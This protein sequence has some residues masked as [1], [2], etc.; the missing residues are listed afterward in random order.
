MK[1]IIQFLL[2]LTALALLPASLCAQQT[3]R[4]TVSGYVTDAETGET[5]I[6][7]AIISGPR[8]GAVT[9]PF[10]YYSLTLP[11]GEVAL[12]FS[13]LGYA[14]ESHTLN[15]QR[16]T[17]LNVSL[18]PSAVLEAATVTALSR[19][20]AGIASTYLGS[21][22]V[23]LKQIKSTPLLFGEADV[24]KALQKIPGVQGGNEGFTGL[25]V[26]GGG[27]DENL[28]MLDGSPIYN[29]DHLLGLFS[30][31]QT[32][33]VKKVTL[34]KGSFPARYGGRIS[35]I[36]DIRTNDGNLKEHS[37]SV[38]VGL[39]NSRLHLEG[40]I[41]KDKLSYSFSARGF[42]TILF[43]P[44][45]QKFFDSDINGNYY[46]YDLNGKLSWRLSDR[47]RFF[48]G[49]YSGA[50]AIRY[51]E[52]Y[53][54]EDIVNT[55]FSR[56]STRIKWGNDVVH[57]RWNHVFSSRLFSNTTLAFN[58]YRMKLNST[59]TER[60]LVYGSWIRDHYDVSYF[61]GIRDWS[62]RTDF[63][64][65]PAPNRIV[66]FGGEYVYH[67][68]RPETLTAIEESIDG[69]GIT[70]TQ[71]YNFQTHDSY[72]GHE[73]SAYGEYEYALPWNL[74]LDPGLRATLFAVEGRTY[75]SLQPR[76]NLKYDVPGVKALSLKAGYSRMA[77]YVHLLSTLQI[78]MPTDLWV[79][80]TKDIRPVLSDQVSTGV[81]YSG[82]PGWE[83]SLEGYLKW[84][85]NILEYSDGTIMIGTSSNWESRVEMG[86][87]RARGLELLVQKTHGD[88]TGWLSYTL[89][90]SERRFPDGS[91]NLG[92]WFPYKYDRR[93]C[94][95]VNMSYKLT[96]RTDFNFAWTYASGTALTIPEGK[97]VVA[98]P[99]GH[100]AEA[101]YIPSRNNWR[102]PA[103]HH[104]D[105]SF[106]VHSPKTHG[107]SIWTFGVYNVYNRRNPNF[108][109]L[110]DE[111][112]YPKDANGNVTDYS[113]GKRRLLLETISIL[114]ILPSISYTRE[115]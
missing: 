43:I 1:R 72:N 111:I 77:Q 107:Q 10:G 26:R 11:S 48:L 16:D 55:T 69:E 60:T 83:F 5:L 70:D 24:L 53:N 102:L 15:L 9:N 56:E 8:T 3:D 94:L 47:D 86:Q 85:N 14:E 88:L 67:T 51:D 4:V 27:P 12:Q 30:V 39:L 75:F 92:R 44:L 109:Y 57:L 20:D 54:D 40:P 50:D 34:Y 91:I 98:T 105:I 42:N 62:A 99:N 38:T 71:K 68:F 93:H 59:S 18:S 45:L 66:R 81:Y 89:A 61:S 32:E 73:M 87:G 2:L 104:L 114:P 46:F 33:A 90:K 19:A 110:S 64:W 78:S 25:Y 103:S 79:P 13:Y 35:S 112:E 58:R 52:S 65:H 28:I 97:T 63:D 100:Y 36:V 17:L 84:M 101:D 37:G 29:V 22:D 76:V 80:I 95:N 96:D 108:T 21:V 106:E 113:Q 49:A 41:V 82:L 23:P 31:F 7:A 6:G 74:T 115:F